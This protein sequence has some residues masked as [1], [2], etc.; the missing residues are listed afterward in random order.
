MRRMK[1]MNTNF[2]FIGR[3]A[4]KTDVIFVSPP[5]GVATIMLKLVHENPVKGFPFVAKRLPSKIFYDAKRRGFQQDNSNADEIT[6]FVARCSL[7]Q[8]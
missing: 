5:I 7:Q 2:Y 1:R 8:K 4:G 3:Y 6:L